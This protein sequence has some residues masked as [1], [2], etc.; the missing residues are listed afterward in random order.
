MSTGLLYEMRRVFSERER[1]LITSW[2]IGPNI[3][4]EGVL[5]DQR[6]GGL[7]DKIFIAKLSI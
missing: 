4:T 5:D 6:V 7:G 3:V 2:L 1:E